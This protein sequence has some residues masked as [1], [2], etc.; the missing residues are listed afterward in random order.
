MKVKN[1]IK[2]YAN[3][4]IKSIGHIFKSI[5]KSEFKQ[6]VVTSRYDL[7][8]TDKNRERSDFITLA[9]VCGWEVVLECVK[10][11]CPMKKGLCR[12]GCQYC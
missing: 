5:C 4:I 7:Q 9:L 6:F 3:K 12:I 10:T 8:F 2:K 1:T 11:Y